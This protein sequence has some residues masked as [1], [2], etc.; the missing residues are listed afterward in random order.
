MSGENP[1]AAADALLPRLVGDT[2]GAAQAGVDAHTV[3]SAN[4]GEWRRSAR[5]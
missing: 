2:T 1:R 4:T 3:N 5:R